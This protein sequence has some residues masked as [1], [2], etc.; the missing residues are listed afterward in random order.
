MFYQHHLVESSICLGSIHYFNYHQ[1]M[2]ELSEFL[3]IGSSKAEIWAHSMSVSMAIVMMP[4]F[5]A[6]TEC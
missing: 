6:S 5:Q 2:N 4:D 1:K 3:K